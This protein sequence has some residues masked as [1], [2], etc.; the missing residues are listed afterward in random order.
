MERS[1]PKLRSV[2]GGLDNELEIGL[3]NL[4]VVVEEDQRIPIFRFPWPLEHNRAVVDGR[5]YHGNFVGCAMSLVDE[6]PGVVVFKPNVRRNAADVGTDV[7]I[8]L[9]DPEKSPGGVEQKPPNTA[10]C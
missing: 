4:I 6:L 8:K 1:D 2:V 9:P 3:E 5:L 10:R 7:A